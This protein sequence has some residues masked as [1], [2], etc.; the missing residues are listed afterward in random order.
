[1]TLKQGSLYQTKQIRTLEQLAMKT[2]PITGHEL[3][4]AAGLAAFECFRQYWPKVK[5]IAVFCGGGNNGGD[6]MV[7]AQH[8]FA[9]GYAVTIYL[10]GSPQTEESKAAFQSCEQVQIP[11]FPFDSSITI[12]ADVL[13]DAICGIGL[14][15]TLRAEAASAVSFMQAC[16]LPIFSLDVPTGLDADTGQVMG[17]AIKA[18]V[19]ITFIGMKLGLFM[20][21]GLAHAGQLVCHDLNLPSSLFDAVHPVAERLDVEDYRPFLKPRLRDWHKGLSGHVLIVGGGPG[22][23]G[24]SRL[25]AEAALRVGAGLVT[26]ATHPDHAALLNITRPEIMCHGI[27]NVSELNQLLERADVL[28]LGPGLTQNDWALHLFQAVVSQ[29]HPMVVDADGLNLLAKH[30]MHHDHWVLTPHP[31]EAARLLQISTEEVQADRFAAVQ[32]IQQKFGGVCVLKG[33]GT[34]IAS[35]TL[36]PSICDQG[37]A[38]M[39]TAGMGDVLSG[40]IGGLLSQGVPMEQ[41]ARLG[42]VWHAIAG[43]RAAKEGERG[44]LAM[45]L[46]PHLR[47][48]S[49]E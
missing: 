47:Q 2:C 32:T 24:A 36:M 9:R 25:A 29:S 19:T 21:V 49:N 18:D 48:L 6:G 27:H 5:R 37:N 45:D 4:R 22:F 26:I 3:M 35:N 23:S 16:A 15:K 13:V 38:G 44:L 8:A 46:F 43:D 39:A 28:I 11:I 12:Q 33:A 17:V 41:A 42:V 7:F 1:M 20:P 31:G 34:I 30:P 40:V 10:V 14:N